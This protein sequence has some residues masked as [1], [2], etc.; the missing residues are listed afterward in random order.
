MNLSSNLSWSQAVAGMW[1]GEQSLLEPHPL[2]GHLAGLPEVPPRLDDGPDSTKLQD[3]PL[4]LLFCE[5]RGPSHP[6][7]KQK[8]QVTMLVYKCRPVTK[9]NLNIPMSH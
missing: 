3:H 1:G 8:L 5:G 9:P 6:D 4:L 2:G 7:L